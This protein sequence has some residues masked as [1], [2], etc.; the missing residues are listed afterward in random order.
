MHYYSY[1]PLLV[2]LHRLFKDY[3]LLP[4]KVHS[5][6]ERFGDSLIDFSVVLVMQ[7]QSRPSNTCSSNSDTIWVALLPWPCCFPSSQLRCCCHH[8]CLS[9]VVI[10]QSWRST[11]LSKLTTSVMYVYYWVCIIRRQK[12]DLLDLLFFVQVRPPFSR[13]H[14][15]CWILIRV[16]QSA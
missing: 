12:R 11:V 5:K 10:E 4:Y 3:N 13:D 15:I 9:C 14:L 1:L 2:M 8:Q 16:K 6:E 7:E